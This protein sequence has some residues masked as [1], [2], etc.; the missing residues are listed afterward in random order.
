MKTILI[1]FGD[2]SSKHIQVLNEFDCE[3]VGVFSRDYEYAKL[4]GEKLGISNIFRTLEETMKVD[5]DFFLI[6]TSAEYNCNVLKQFIPLKKPILIEKP[7]GFSSHELD[8]A[9]K[10]NQYFCTPIMVGANRRFYSIF[11]LALDYLNSKNLKIN[12]IYVEAPER[13]SDIAK[14]KFS[15]NTKHHWMFVN[16]IHCID[17]IRFFSGDI[18]KIVSFSNP[19]ELAF[20]AI[21]VSEKNIKFMYNS[22][23][24]SP[25]NWSI[26]IYADDVRIV[27]NPLENCKIITKDSTKEII[28]SENDVKFKPGFY[29]Q[30]KHFLENVVAK[31]QFIWPCSDLIDHKKSLEIIE[32]IFPTTL[33]IPFKK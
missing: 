27:F 28:P 29:F 18:K 24:S 8:D 23:W 10:L 14:D 26:T 4:E 3:I 33:D 19:S 6:M 15:A 13:L 22:N 20:N 1:G 16:S 25:G 17:L 12:S 32:K 2:I 9:I 31:N 11:H 21:G 5:C 7:V 30:L